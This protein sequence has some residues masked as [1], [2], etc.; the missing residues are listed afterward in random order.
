[1]SSSTGPDLKGIGWRK[2]SC[3]MANGNCVEVASTSRYVHVRDSAKPGDLT[4]SFTENA[5]LTFVDVLRNGKVN[6]R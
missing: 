3:S 2:S 5:W 1:M 6:S 4:V